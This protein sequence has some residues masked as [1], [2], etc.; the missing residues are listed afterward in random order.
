M[1]VPGYNEEILNEKPHRRFNPLTG[2][3]VLV[4]PHRT[5]RPWQGKNEKVPELDKAQYDPQCYLC[6]GNSRA[7]GEV[8]PDYSD[9][10][11]FTN[12]FSA[13]LPDGF[14]LNTAQNEIFQIEEERGICKVLCFSPIH[15]LTLA[16]MDRSAIV[17]VIETWRDEYRELGSKEFI[18]HVQI[19]EN[20]G[21]IM[22]CS[23]P[24]PHGQI[25]ATQSIPV[26][27][28]KEL[29]QQNIYFDKYG[30]T[31]LS[32]YLEAELKNGQRL[33]LEND[34]FAVL[35]PFW[36]VWPYESI[37]ISKRAISSLLEF[38]E[39][40]IEDYADA[41][42]R[43]TSKYDHLFEVSFPYSA[44]LHQAP[45]NGMAH[46]AWHFH[47]HFYPPLLR[48]ATVKKF[49]VGFEMLATPQRDI[50]A[51]QAAKILKELPE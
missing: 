13:I 27:P 37:I 47:M 40:E 7:G 32:D 34:S 33:I 50:T 17:K 45:T 21:D 8:N 1:E 12:D 51:E 11:V 26:E 39:K 3:W 35:V 23:N 28:S 16:K 44:G 41:M 43:L 10:F 14:E 15:D 42:K 25:W 48:S 22:G 38:T 30:R 24:H 20:R 19:F 4:S 46:P 49:M 2:E 18:N 9:V 6:P 31:L 36:A 29:E 5:K